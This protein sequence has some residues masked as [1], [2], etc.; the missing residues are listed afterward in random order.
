VEEYNSGLLAALR[1]PAILNITKSPDQAAGFSFGKID[2]DHP[3]FATMFEREN[4]KPKES[5][6]VLGSPVITTTLQRQSGKQGHSIIALGDGIPFLSEHTFGEGRI[7]FFS[8]APTLTW[9]DF[10]LKAIFA[11]LIFRSVMYT[12]LR[13]ET[14]TAY[15][16]GDEALIRVQNA[17]PGGE[18]QFTIVSPDGIEELIQPASQANAPRGPRPALVFQLKRFGMPGWYELRNGTFPLAVIAVNADSRESDI[19]KV[20]DEELT[21]FWNRLNIPPSSIRTIARGDEIQTTIL[22]SRFGVEMWKYCIAGALLLALAEML[23]AR[24]SSKASGQSLAGQPA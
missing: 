1:I 10:P 15:V 6:E 9:S 11:P 14:Q 19:R 21:A 12:A 20:S 17:R 7:L 24:D 13:T 5:A 2:I 16:A 22:Q 3:V 23:I 18:H 4:R 8:V